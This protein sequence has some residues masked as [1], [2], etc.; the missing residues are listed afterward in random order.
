ML[1]LRILLQSNL[2]Y[3]VILVSVLIVALFRVYI[4]GSESKYQGDETLIIG[5]ITNVIRRE[6]R[7]N[8]TIKGKEKIK[9]TYLTEDYLELGMMV[10]IKG[11]LRLPYN[12]TIPNTFNYKRYLEN[13]NIFYNIKVNS[14][15]IL[16]PNK[17]T[18]YK[19]KNN[20]YK[21]LDGFE[22]AGDYLK[23]FIIGDKTDMDREVYEAYQVNGIAHLFAIS[24]MHLNLLSGFL[25]FGLK[26]YKHKYILIAPLMIGYALLTNY[27]ASIQRALLFFI[28][29]IINRELDFK[30][31]T[32]N[33]LFLTVS[34][35]ILFQPK[36][37]FDLGFQYSAT[38][39]YGLIIA[40][41][42][43]RK[44]YFYNLWITS[45]VAFLFSLPITLMTWYEIN[46]FGIFYNLLFVPLISLVIYPLAILVLVI[47]F[48]EPILYMLT[49]FMENLNL[50]LGDIKFSR[51]IIPKG[52]LA[53]YLVYYALLICYFYSS[54]KRF[55]FI[56][57]LLLL[58]LKLKYHLDFNTYVYY[59]DV[60]QG[61]STLIYNR[62]ETILIDT[63]GVSYYQISNSTMTFM[64]S[65][66]I[67]K[68]DLMI[69]THGD[70]DH[71]L[72]APTII[73]KF[74]VKRVMINK[75]PINELEER[76]ISA[77]VKMVEDYESSF[78]LKIINDY[79]SNDE[80]NSS[81]I[82]YLIINSFGLL[83]TGDAYKEVE[84]RLI[85]D[86]RVKVDIAKLGHHG[87]KTSSD[88]RFLSFI[89]A[90][91]AI[92]SS[93]R[94]NLYRHP[95]PNTIETLEK[96]NINYYN[97]A[98]KGTIK[99]TF[100]RNHYTKGFYPP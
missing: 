51:I 76:I 48:L 28:L 55:V 34:I 61:D 10:Q 56:G 41:R 16:E 2:I 80:N 89:G 58:S 36:I 1:R 82:A 8:L 83:F 81:I 43:Y 40:R 11:E 87:S 31:K 23:T 20:L 5:K 70:A 49:S 68:I 39:T 74:N 71:L 14:L 65:V 12:N 100:R 85:N 77:G 26:K 75:N 15:E 59:L 9:A 95:H 57:V 27:S 86:Y 50:M 92:I 47:G 98:E 66:G 3:L 94:N 88:E 91:E 7:Y 84:L 37:I 38:V 53:V 33:I 6:N 18:I 25:I 13:Q 22:Y 62:K 45:V 35:L 69:L 4:I 79:L 19:I 90:K 21:Y 46:L 73:K 96:L 29:M 42:L 97:T 93:G 60:G 17:N 78:N 72:D 32:R 44:N 99:Y 63:G 64:R 54:R 67:T 52:P 30:I 24:G